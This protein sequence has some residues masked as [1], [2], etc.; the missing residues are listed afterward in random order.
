VKLGPRVLVWV[1]D[2]GI[3]AHGTS[4]ASVHV[5]GVVRGLEAAGFQVTL[6]VRTIADHRPRRLI[7]LHAVPVVG[8][9]EASVDRPDWI[10]ER[11]SLDATSGP[12]AA[13]TWRVPRLLEVN[14]P[15]VEER[16]QTARIPDLAGVRA[17]VQHNAVGADRVLVVSA[18]L[19]GWARRLGVVP[20]RLRHVPNGASVSDPGDRAT[21]RRRLGWDGPVVGVLGSGRPWHGLARLPAIADLLPGWTVAVIGPETAIH[22]RIR[23]LGPIPEEAVGEI[24]AALDVGL[25]PTPPDAPPWFDPLK[26]ADFRA[27]GVPVVAGIAPNTPDAWAAAVLAARGADRTPHVRSWRTVVEEALADPGAR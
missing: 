3:P 22:P 23:G 18:W 26:R 5:R 24:L 25:I 10:W 17:A 4:G 21:T 6:A 9:L 15:V 14:A 12:D 8:P 20:E 19:H 2:R 13:A 27:A 7:P 1:P 11:L 16:L